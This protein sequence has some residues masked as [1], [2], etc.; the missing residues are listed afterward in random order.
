MSDMSPKTFVSPAKYIVNPSSSSR[1]APH[2]SPP[3]QK[4]SPHTGLQVPAPHAPLRHSAGAAQEVSA[5]FR[6][7][8]AQIPVHAFRLHPTGCPPRLEVDELEEGAW[9]RHDRAVARLEF[10]DLYGL[11]GNGYA[12]VDFH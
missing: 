2:A 7:I 12:Y 1:T 4:P 9:C 6:Q 11:T 5:G 3:S 8:E 10:H